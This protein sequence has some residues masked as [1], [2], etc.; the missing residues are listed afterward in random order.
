M[1]QTG[2]YGTG[3][4]KDA[5]ARVWITEGTGEVTVN[6]KPLSEYLPR[7]TLAQIV[8]QPFEATETVGRFSVRAYAKGGGPSGQAGALRHGIA[9][10]L[11]QFDENLRGVLRRRGYL[12]RDPRV[13]ERKHA[14]FRRARRGKQFSKR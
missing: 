5:T 13:K 12:T 3:H 1:Q 2:Y 6:G 8:Q 14:G 4:R 10:A 11:V 7:E 9:K